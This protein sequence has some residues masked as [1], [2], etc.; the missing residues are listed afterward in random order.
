M[1]PFDWRYWQLENKWSLPHNN[2]FS[3]TSS[4]SSDDPKL[5]TKRQ[6][7]TA[8]L[9]IDRK[10]HK[11]TASILIFTRTGICLA[12]DSDGMVIIHVLFTSVGLHFCSHG[13]SVSDSRALGKRNNSSSA[14]MSCNVEQ[15]PLKPRESE[16]YCWS[17]DSEAL[18]YF[19]GISRGLFPLQRYWP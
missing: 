6:T 7:V 5:A 19:C 14:T 13:V 8:M 9:G 15:W 12:S 16:R 3:V 1:C 10:A 18:V 2:T 4:S 11:P 17:L